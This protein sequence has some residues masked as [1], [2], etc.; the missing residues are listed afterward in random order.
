MSQL[1]IA[2]AHSKSETSWRFACVY[3]PEFEMAM[4][5]QAQPDIDWLSPMALID[6]QEHARVK[7]C[8]EV[9]KA[10]GVYSEQRLTQARRRCADL[11]YY[12]IKPPLIA[13]GTQRFIRI[14]NQVTPRVE[15]GHVWPGIFWLDA[16]GMRWLGGESGLADKAIRSVK[17]E[18]IHKVRVGIA[19]TML[20][21]QAAA[22]RASDETEVIIVPPGLDSDFLQGL[23]LV[24][25]ALPAFM[26][27]TLVGLG[28]ETIKDLMTLPPEALAV[29][30]GLSGIL[31]WR[32]AQGED[33]RRMT[34]QVPQLLPEA[35]LVLD[36][37]IATLAP[38]LFGMRSLVEQVA[39]QLIH[40][41]MATTCIRLSFLLETGQCSHQLL[42][43]V[44]ATSQVD[45]LVE[46]IKVRLEA[47]DREPLDAAVTELRLCALE[48]APASWLQGQFAVQRWDENA[49]ERALESLRSRFG[50]SVVFEAKS[51]QDPRPERR[52]VWS[53]MTEVPVLGQG[54]ETPQRL[55]PPEA[56]R[57]VFTGPK[58]AKL[59]LDPHG[60]PIEIYWSGR[61]VSVDARG[62]ERLSGQWW[63]NGFA[64]EDYRLVLPS[65]EVLWARRDAHARTWSLM[66]WFD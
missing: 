32:H 11:K 31:A 37:P 49:V 26:R 22:L 42:Y 66:G 13:H 48:L 38:L 28:I 20:T 63:T 1:S 15:S 24:D 12:A 25:L 30:F 10:A 23:S 5:L 53:T 62:P 57:R 51:C 8:N 35:T 56:I 47:M 7:A 44:R 55:T 65:D 50:Y 4:C 17:A 19:D 2:G 43:P 54:E 36:G 18:G 9:A 60:V 40:H 34:G 27:D 29:R 21:A 46:L 61:W 39:A 45:V 6:T 64:Y 3:M 16:R 14:L 58:P 41:A 59:R 52:A 33:V